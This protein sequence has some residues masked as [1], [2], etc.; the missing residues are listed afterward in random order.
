VAPTNNPPLIGAGHLV[1]EAGWAAERSQI[2]L[3]HWTHHL[4]QLQSDRKPPSVLIGLQTPTNRQQPYPPCPN[5]LQPLSFL[6]SI[7]QAD[8]AAA[9]GSLAENGPAA[10]SAVTR[11][12]S[13]THLVQSTSSTDMILCTGFRQW[14]G[15]IGKRG[16]I[17]LQITPGILIIFSSSGRSIC[18]ACYGPS[19]PLVL[20]QATTET[21]ILLTAVYRTGRQKQNK[22]KPHGRPNHGIRSAQ[23]AATAIHTPRPQRRCGSKTTRRVE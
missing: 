22:E 8:P 18:Q 3:E 15:Q 1:E 10:A 13:V 23:P 11:R 14:G 6:S 5:P 9:R 7:F 20:A 16:G 17:A 4:H 21:P 19:P 12:S 2:S